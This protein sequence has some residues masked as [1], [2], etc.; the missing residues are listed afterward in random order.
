MPERLIEA[1]PRFLEHAE[2]LVNPDNFDEIKG[3]MMITY[4]NSVVGSLSQ[5]FR[6]TGFAY[7]QALT[8]VKE[9]ARPQKHAYHLANS[10]FAEPVGNYYGETYFG[11]DA[12][13]DVTRMVEKNGTNLQ[14]P[15]S[16]K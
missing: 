8:G 2:S 12:K 5:E 7:N 14:K 4:I 15:Y 3:W 10:R 11:D 16:S 13:Q 1:E 9:M 6:E